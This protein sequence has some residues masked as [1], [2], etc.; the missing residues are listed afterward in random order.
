MKTDHISHLLSETGAKRWLSR[1]RDSAPNAL[2]PRTLKDVSSRRYDPELFVYSDSP[3]MLSMTEEL[4]DELSS[5]LPVDVLD[6]GFA[7]ETAV[8]TNFYSVRAVSGY[9]SD[10]LALPSTNNS[11]FVKELGLVNDIRPADVPYLKKIIELFFGH[12][13]PAPLHIRKKAS[14]SFPF[15]TS[16]NQYKKMAAMKAL[17]NIDH[18]LKCSTGGP[19]SL[20][21]A[22]NDY[23]SLILYALHERGQADS[24]KCENGNYVTKVRKAATPEESRQG[25]PG[26]ITIDSSIKV[27]GILVPGHFAM[28]RRVVYGMCGVPNYVLTAVIGCHRA[29]Y[30]KRFASTYKTRGPKDKEEKISRFKYVVGSDVKS[31]DTTTPRWFF[32]FLL[33]ELTQYWDES[34]VELLRRM[35]YASF[36]SPPPSKNTP[37]NYDPLFGPDPLS[38]EFNLATGLPSGIAI[39]PDLGKLWMTFVYLILYRD[40]GAIRSPADIESFL[41]GN[42]RDHGM[43]DMGDDATLMTN[44]ISVRDKLMK[45]SSPYAVLEPETPV[46]FLGDVFAT[47]AGQSRAFPNPVT[48]VVNM[49]ARENSIDRMNPV[50]YAEGYL[51]RHQHYSATP[52][53][54]EINDTFERLARK[55]LNINP[56]TLAKG[57]ARKQRFDSLEAMLRENEHYLHYRIDPA[58]VSPE[59]LDE[60]VATIPAVDFYNDIRHLF[61]VPTTAYSGGEIGENYGS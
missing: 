8:P 28:R 50:S 5:A 9:L 47:R 3:D 52:K 18:Y 7:G 61:K 27:D 11:G 60:I 22:L 53:F 37:D 12:V 23:H 41:S 55:H 33:N 13:Q 2:F 16:D 25:A 35:L 4:G 29:V 34:L 57:I 51:A 54:A 49:I 14:T 15:F 17:K 48:Y 40:A 20:K 56:L 36:V 24:V 1:P 31:M 45:A 32:E 46:I 44:S 38:G 39:N 10:P 59:V 19:A 6:T 42:N 30:L 26:S 21:T 43:L 58:D